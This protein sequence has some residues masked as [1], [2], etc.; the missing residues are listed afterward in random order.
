MI[1]VEEEPQN[2]NINSNDSE[3]KNG[4]KLFSPKIL[5]RLFNSFTLV[6]ISPLLRLLILNKG[7]YNK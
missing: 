7:R 2:N 5:L 1:M 6:N 3:L 4:Q